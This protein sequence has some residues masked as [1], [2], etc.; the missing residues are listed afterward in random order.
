M[1]W[2]I[3]GQEILNGFLTNKCHCVKCRNVR[4]VEKT[5]I[6]NVI[7]MMSKQ[8]SLL[9]WSGSGTNQV[10]AS[11]HITPQLNYTKI[12]RIQRL[13]KYGILTSG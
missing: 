11:G 12:K 6:R 7:K 1:V 2:S 4:A 10:E 3:L 5:K 8:I 13:C 9:V